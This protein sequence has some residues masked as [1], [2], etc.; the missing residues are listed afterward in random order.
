MKTLIKTST[1]MICLTAMLVGVRCDAGEIDLTIVPKS[2]K[3]SAKGMMKEAKSFTYGNEHEEQQLWIFTPDHLKEAELRPCVFFIHGGGWGGD[4]YYFAPQSIHLSRLGIVCVS[5]HF[6]NAKETPKNCLADCLS[7][8]RWVKANGRQHHI[9]PEKIVV[10]GGSAGGHLALAMLTIP[11]C[12]N[13]KD[14]KSIPIDPKGL[15]LFNPVIDLVEGWGAGR[16]KCKQAGVNPEDF[17]PAHHMRPGLPETLILSGS[18]DGLIPPRLIHQYIERTGKQGNVC[19]FVE[20]PG[21]DHSFFNH[22]KD[23]RVDYFFQ[24]MKETEGFLTKLGYL[25]VK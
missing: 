20:Y 7:A 17:S 16:E 8:Y 24:T 21:A 2:W 25:P 18:K 13:P 4:P 14:D 19:R 11:G 23:G 12:D 22:G 3:K 9:D 6:R 1:I 10:S 5:I 15:V